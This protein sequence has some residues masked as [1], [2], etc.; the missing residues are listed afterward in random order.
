MHR[1]VLISLAELKDDHWSRVLSCFFVQSSALKS[2]FIQL[3]FVLRG[4]EGGG[5]ESY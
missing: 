1:K 3:H 4:K 2:N 5:G